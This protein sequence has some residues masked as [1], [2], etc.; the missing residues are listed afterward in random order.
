MQDYSIE[1]GFTH[2]FI[3][4]LNI[5]IQYADKVGRLR[6]DAGMS[7]EAYK[8]NYEK[9]KKKQEFVLKP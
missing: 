5:V 6:K 8:E 7:L 9:W 1:N 3:D 2:M 4:N